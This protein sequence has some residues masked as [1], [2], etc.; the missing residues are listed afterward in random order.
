MADMTESPLNPFPGLR[1]F[2]AEEDFL[3]FGRE[4]QTNELLELLRVHR[5]LAVVGTSGSGKSSLVRAGLLPA[6][7]GGTMVSVGSRWEVA[8]MRPG[9]DPI[10][11]LA[12]SLIDCDLYDPDDPESLPRI[13]ATLRRSRN[14]LVEAI[15]QSDLGERHNL[16]LVV[17]Q[18]EE[19]FRFRADSIEQQEVASEFAQLL[20][21]AANAKDL[22]IYVTLTMRSDYLGECAQIS[23]LAEAVNHGEYL[24][25][26]LTRDQRRDA[27]ERPVAVGGGKISGRLI[28]QLLNEVGD[29]VDQLPVLQHTLMRVW[30]HWENDHQE[31]E[32]I[33][34]RHYE[35]VGGLNHALS[36][37]ADEVYR[38][39]GTEQA[40]L[41]CERIFKALTECGTDARGIRRPTN[42]GMLCQIVDG[43]VGE[44]STVLDAFRKVGRTFVMPQEDVPIES[45]T[46]VDISHESLMR[47]WQRLR[48]WVDEESQSARVYRR[49]AETA[50]LFADNRAGH[51]RDPDLSIASAWREQNTPNRH[52]ADRYFV[53]FENAV[54]FL[55]QSQVAAKSEE[56]KLELR[57][58][59]EL[60]QARQLAQAQQ[61]ARRRSQGFMVCAIVATIIVCL[62]WLE[63]DKSAEEAAESA[64]EAQRNELLAE[65]NA[66]KARQNEQFAKDARQA[67]EIQR[68]IAESEAQRNRLG[69]YAASIRQAERE[70]VSSASR[71]AGLLELDQW[72]HATGIDGT[73]NSPAMRDWEWYYLKGLAR[74]LNA[75]PRIESLKLGSRVNFAGKWSPD[76]KL[77]AVTGLGKQ[78][79]IIDALSKQIIQSFS[80]KTLEFCPRIQWS[81]DA[82]SI[83]IDAWWG[84][85]EVYDVQT[86]LLTQVLNHNGG[87]TNSTLSWNRHQNLIAYSLDQGKIGI[88]DM[89]HGQL[90]HVIPTSS[91]IHAI[92]WSPDGKQLAYS[93]IPGGLHV[94]D[95]PSLE[96]SY[97][98]GS[99]YVDR[100]RWT[101][102]G[103]RIICQDA[104]PSQLFV[105]TPAEDTHTKAV[106]SGIGGIWGMAMHPD[107]PWVA[108]SGPRGEIGLFD[109]EQLKLSDSITGFSGMMVGVDWRPQGDLLFVSGLTQGAT[110]LVDVS[111]KRR[112]LLE[113]GVD[114]TGDDALST[115][116]DCKLAPDGHRVSFTSDVPGRILIAD[117]SVQ[118]ITSQIETPLNEL[119]Y[120]YAWTGD[121]KR[122]AVAGEKTLLILD[123]NS[124]SQVDASYS[125]EDIGRV[126]SLDWSSD[127]KYLAFTQGMNAK[128]DWGVFQ[129]DQESLQLIQFD[130]IDSLPNAVSWHPTKPILAVGLGQVGRDGSPV[131]LWDV[132]DQQLLLTIPTNELKVQDL[133]FS[134]E[135]DRLA[136]AFDRPVGL[137][138]F[139]SSGSIAVFS[140]VDG[141]SLGNFPRQSVRLSDIQWNSTDQRIATSS[142]DGKVRVWRD[143]GTELLTLN[144]FESAPVR[145]AFWDSSG[146]TLIA[147]S[148]R[149]TYL[150]S[151]SIEDSLNEV[152][153]Q[154]SPELLGNLVA[155]AETDPSKIANVYAASG[156][157]ANAASIFE[158]LAAENEEAVVFPTRYWR[159]RE[160]P[161]QL[162][163][164]GQNDRLALDPHRVE[165]LLSDF[166][167]PTQ[168]QQPNAFISNWEYIGQDSTRFNLQGATPQTTEAIQVVAT[169]YY[170]SRP[171]SAALVLGGGENVF[172]WHDGQL[173][174]EHDRPGIMSNGELGVVLELRKGWNDLLFVVYSETKQL[175]LEPYLLETPARILS[176]SSVTWDGISNGQFAAFVNA[177][178]LSESVKK[179]IEYQ[180][181]IQAGKADAA[182]SGLRAIDAK[183]QVTHFAHAAMLQEAGRFKQALQ[184]AEELYEDKPSHHSAFT[185]GACL[186]TED[187]IPLVSSAATWHSYSSNH[188][189]ADFD[190]PQLLAEKKPDDERVLKQ[191]WSGGGLTSWIG[192]G[193]FPRSISHRAA[194]DVVLLQAT[195]ENTMPLKTLLFEIDTLDGFV[196]YLDGIEC[197]RDNLKGTDTFNLRAQQ[198]SP[199]HNFNY[200]R[201]QIPLM[202][203]LAPGK[204]ELAVSVHQDASRIHLHV[205][206]PT[207]TGFSGPQVETRETQ[208]PEVEL[209]Y[210]LVSATV[211][212]H[213]NWKRVNALIEEGIDPLYVEDQSRH[214]YAV[215]ESTRS[216][217]NDEKI[218]LGSLLSVASLP[219]RSF[220]IALAIEPT[221]RKND[222]AL[223]HRFLR[224]W[225]QSDTIDARLMAAQLLEKIVVGKEAYGSARDAVFEDLR[226]EQLNSNQQLLISTLA[227]TELTKKQADL[228]RQWKSQSTIW[229]TRSSDGWMQEIANALLANQ[230]PDK[231]TPRLEG[232][233]RFELAETNDPIDR[234]LVSAVLSQSISASDT[235]AAGE[236]LELQ[237]QLHSEIVSKFT[238]Q[239]EMPVYL[240][241]WIKYQLA[242]TI[243][244]DLDRSTARSR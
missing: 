55:E 3:F 177:S 36:Q 112:T 129:F 119:V 154:G 64:K 89:D 116:L 15:R 32:P 5:F 65:Q 11:N 130:G 85:V 186:A 219:A 182:D 146:G 218:S 164:L 203:E 204:H 118:R 197:Y 45:T 82:G 39:L 54:G 77:L 207:L 231:T 8:V 190:I 71:N 229:A 103:K 123:G 161:G 193:G 196:V 178:K 176:N 134:N 58:Q 169:R 225:Q 63:A 80:R 117:L 162:A 40:Q 213:F 143:D 121:G 78:V 19:L 159:L 199:Q 153:V 211:R 126:A 69:L 30:D 93:V 181:G 87:N 216:L 198:N 236:R 243:L 59:R 226:F 215:L 108:L 238:K 239:G 86:G 4:Q 221:L 10:K 48:Q 67:A 187:G 155:K 244:S 173:V 47:V 20:L 51:Y 136:V 175:E 230:A 135:G 149:N 208:P 12:Q 158:R 150:N 205:R 183:P 214:I 83:A 94:I 209:A 75:D 28:N 212:G 157:F 33:D 131:Q 202:M 57:R 160:L 14:G 201:R 90:A 120:S 151:W 133:E 163:E 61:K 16:L 144:P 140:T 142:F 217:T 122:L 115:A 17:D 128:S 228:L 188:T 13:M 60:E 24:I 106:E 95:F 74:S 7:F 104:Q 37:H 29:D 189:G 141:E 43:S 44:V 111:K 232:L 168:W 42:M 101:P 81:P 76:G 62:F 70:L 38:E 166:L 9:G 206:C 235:V 100:L 110:M 52:W 148:M 91:R 147:C 23:G 79:L 26:R 242:R 124:P 200:S 2:A 222:S 192:N 97:K 170:S 234:Y 179:T 41:L 96:V 102:D 139:E 195:F 6:L 180:L 92:E 72:N 31:G 145:S 156:Q 114:R 107:Q 194:D 46:V 84:A 35:S 127:G 25:P 220:N 50:V 53:G 99:R 240:E 138:A 27:I 109:Y 172:V 137:V 98:L 56:Q 223:M 191:E 66:D 165:S 113:T 167:T 185:L 233:L 210:H 49:L 171:T 125:L 22:P 227:L 1:P 105:V 184:Y 21:N 237:D 224:D 88:Y 241:Q 73:A 174:L 34:I 132:N 152:S 18:F 68:E